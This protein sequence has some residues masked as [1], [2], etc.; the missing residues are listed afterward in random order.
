MIP[1]TQYCQQRSR[2]FCQAHFGDPDWHSCIE[3][4]EWRVRSESRERRRAEGRVAKWNAQCVE[5]LKTC[6]DWVG[7][8]RNGEG[9][10]RDSVRF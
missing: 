4:A 6:R 7:F 8:C 3:E 9:I 10:G 2:W 1:A 5:V